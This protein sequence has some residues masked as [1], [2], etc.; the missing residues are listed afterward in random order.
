MHARPDSCGQRGRRTGPVSQIAGR[1]APLRRGQPAS[2]AADDA[3]ANASG[4]RS[5]GGS[6]SHMH[7]PAGWPI[8]GAGGATS[9][10]PGGALMARPPLTTE[11]LTA[12]ASDADGCGGRRRQTLTMC[13][14]PSSTC[15]TGANEPAMEAPPQKQL[16]MQARGVAR[17]A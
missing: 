9:C 10:G 15:Q 14:P 2:P 8:G 3:D 16:L 13:L 17:V 1:R 12:M 7:Q 4:A 6:S 5:I 11:T